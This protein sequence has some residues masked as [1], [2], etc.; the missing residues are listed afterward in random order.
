MEYRPIESYGLIGDMETAALVGSD[1]SIDFMCFPYFDSPSVFAALLD[2]KKGGRF[3]LAPVL[4]DLQTKQ[5][6]LLDSNILL[7]RFLSDEGVTEIS[8]FMPVGEAYPG[9]QLVRRVKTIRGEIRYRMALQ[10]RFDYGRA[11]HKTKQKDGEVLFIPEEGKGPTLRLR[12]EVPVQVKK[13]DAIAEFSLK[14]NETA[15]FVLEEAVPGQESPASN[16]DFVS[17]SFKA[18]L[19]FWQR[20]IARSNYQGRWREMVNRSALVLKLL[21]SRRYGS[22]VAA[23]TFA[24]PEVIGGKRN[25]D[26]RYT[27]IRDASFS[28]YALI[29]LG[30]TDEAAAFMK[31]IENLCCGLSGED[32]SLHIM[33]GLDGGEDLE[34]EMLSHFEGYRKSS[35]VRV[36]NGAY[37]QLQLDIYGELLDSVYLYNKFGD[38][39]SNRLWSNLAGLVNWVCA[40]WEQ[41]DEGIWEMR[42]GRHDFL[43]SRLMCWVAVDRGLRLARKRSFPAPLD[44]WQATRDRIYTDIYTNFWNP[45]RQAFVQYRGSEHLDAASLLMPLVKF[46]SPIDPSWLSTL[47][48]IREELME[49]S[50]VY[51][52]VTDDYLKGRE[53]TFSACSF[54][55]IECLARAGELEQARL[56]LEKTLGYANHL[57]LYSEELGPRGEHLGNYPQALTH[58]ALISA[59]GHLDRVLSERR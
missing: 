42:G 33:Y 57:G 11:S 26:Y 44:L 58:L 39:I 46:I 55:Y 38:P 49:D 2:H 36:G 15:A 1:G 29:F 37:K 24:L 17:D 30:Y 19:N 7:T 40:H 54:W 22:M 52:Y 4:E 28:L 12:S 8:D 23:P 14:A 43:Y 50:L 31:W 35:P 3:K 27:W 21:T 25:W 13:G 32:R 48:A 18:T 10:P 56:T 6:Y 41:S 5:L 53:G 20:W 51:R 45:K 9:H 34:E 47:S 16:E 59:A